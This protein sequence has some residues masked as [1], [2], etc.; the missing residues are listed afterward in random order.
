MIKD[1]LLSELKKNLPQE[2][3]RTGTSPDPIIV[4][5]AKHPNVG[6]L[7]IWDDGDE[8]T[9][10]IGDIT[11]GHFDSFDSNL[12]QEKMESE[13]VE[14]VVDFLRNMFADKYLLFKMQGG[15]GWQHLD[16]IEKPFKRRENTEYFIWSGL[17][18]VNNLE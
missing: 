5:T 9:V 15:G 14:R 12:T 10:S 11:H 1:K 17:F 4:F 18:D 2:G 6:D 13:I 3:F 7:S 16:Y 8:V